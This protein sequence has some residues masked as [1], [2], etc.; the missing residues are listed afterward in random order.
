MCRILET[1]SCR[2]I[3]EEAVKRELEICGEASGS[4][5]TK[6]GVRK[7]ELP[8]QLLRPHASMEGHIQMYRRAV[9]NLKFLGSL[10]SGPGRHGN[11]ERASRRR[12]VHSEV[13][14]VNQDAFGLGP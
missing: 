12:H 4:K 13:W 10:P 6:Q 3:K 7:F 1:L 11:S 8:V 14:P 9:H 2:E 5:F